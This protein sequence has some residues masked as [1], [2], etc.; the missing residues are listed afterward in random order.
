MS[1]DTR[2]RQSIRK[3]AKSESRLLY[4]IATAQMEREI[5]KRVIKIT[6]ANQELMLTETGVQSTL[7]DEDV[8]QYLW[9]VLTEIKR[10]A[11]SNFLFVEIWKVIYLYFRSAIPDS[12]SIALKINSSIILDLSKKLHPTML[13]THQYPSMIHLCFSTLPVLY[14]R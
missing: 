3:L 4:S 14:R 12:N 13:Y 5:Q 7:T 1:Q 6:R 9:Q 11:N 10:T 2:L 8:K